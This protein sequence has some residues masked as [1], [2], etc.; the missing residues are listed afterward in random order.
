M[1]QR[2]PLNWVFLTLFITGLIV[3]TAHESTYTFE[4]T[5]IITTTLEDVINKGEITIITRNT[6]TTYYVGPEGP[7][8]FEYDLVRFYPIRQSGKCSWESFYL[9]A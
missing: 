8:G 2:S 7:T 9:S 1:I 5:Y 6:P 4:R 3:A